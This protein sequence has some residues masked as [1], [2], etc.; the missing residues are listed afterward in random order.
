M[1]NFLRAA[2]FAACVAAAAPAAAESA[3]TT[4]DIRCVVAIA[5]LAGQSSDP[6]FVQE[7]AM[8]LLYFVGRI[9]GREPGLNLEAT[10]R[11]QAARTTQPML[12]EDL[13]RCGRIMLAKGGE[14]KAI[15]EG[16]QAEAKPAPTS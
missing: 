10:L 6:Q 15:G 1:Q 12:R 13:V 9:E 16:M 11:A 3:E 7:A 8:G 14:L 4:N 5:M 2:A